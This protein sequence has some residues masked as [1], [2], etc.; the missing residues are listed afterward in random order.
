MI[1]IDDMIKLANCYLYSRSDHFLPIVSKLEQSVFNTLTTTT[2]SSNSTNNNNNI[3][4]DV[5]NQ[6][7]FAQIA[8]VVQLLHSARLVGGTACNVTR[9][10]KISERIG[11]LLK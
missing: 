11:N 7:N 3:N 2:S 6:L 9:I 4:I 8:S 5:L 1:N 10:E